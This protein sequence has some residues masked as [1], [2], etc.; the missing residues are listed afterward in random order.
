MSL[1]DTLTKSLIDI[2]AKQLNTQE[3]EELLHAIEII[4][5][6]EK[7]NKFKNIFPDEGPYRRGLYRKH[8]NFFNAG[9]KF[10]ERAFVAGNRIGKCISYDTLVDLPDGTKEKAGILYERGPGFTLNSWTGTGIKECLVTECVKKAP[11]PLVRIWLSNGAHFDCAMNHRIL[12]N[13]TYVFV[14]D[15]IKDVLCLP[16]STEELG[17]KVQFQDVARWFETL[18]N[19]L[20]DYSGGFHPYGEQLLSVRGNDPIS[21]P[22]QGGAPQPAAFLLRR[23]GQGCRRTSNGQLVC[24]LLSNLC[25]VLHGEALSSCVS[26]QLVLTD[27]QVGILSSESTPHSVLA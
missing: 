19:Y 26:D 24:D 10:R 15:L 21:V 22:P 20:G 1:L 11:E 7:Y 13:N 23:D 4:A 8:I 27:A 25:G 5:N 17:L 6:E 9:A 3:Q 18:L 14:A 12:V 16:V 2:Y